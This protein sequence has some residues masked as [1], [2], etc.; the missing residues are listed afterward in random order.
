MRNHGAIALRRRDEPDALVAAGLRAVLRPSVADLRQAVRPPLLSGQ[1]V[2][3]CSVC[4]FLFR[5]T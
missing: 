2:G 4:E 1:L 5:A 3:V